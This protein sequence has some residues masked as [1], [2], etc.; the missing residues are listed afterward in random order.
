MAQF[1]KQTTIAFCLLIL[2][3]VCQFTVVAAPRN[4]AKAPIP[5]W[6]K[7]LPLRLYTN[8]SPEDVNDGYHYVQRSMQW[9]VARQEA[10]FHNTYK[11]TSEEGVQNSS[12]IQLSFDPNH[13]KLYLHKVVVWRNGK[14]KDQL[15]LNKVKVIQREQGLEQ[16]IFDES[17]TALFVLEDVRAGDF[18]EYAWSIK[19]RNP[20]FNGKFFNSFHLQFYDPMDELLVQIIMP[21]QRK[22]NYLLHKTDR[23]PTIVTAN[24]NTSYTWHH[25]N[26]Q[27]TPVDSD[28]PGWYNPYPTATV[29]E[30]NSWKEVVDWALPMYEI[31]ETPSKALQAV[32]DSIRS[33]ARTKEEWLVSALRFV[34]D[35]V[36][37]LGMEAGIGGYKPRSPS[38]VFAQRFGDCKD[39]SLLLATMLK[40]LGIEAYPALV[41]SN[42]KGQIK[43]WQPSPY[44]FNHCIVQVT[45]RGSRL[46]YDP[47]ISK[48][49]G[50]S[51]SNYLPDYQQALV[52][53]ASSKGL[54]Q[55][56]PPLD[57]NGSVKVQE[58]FLF[59]DVGGAV[60]LKV[61]T[62]Y[63]GWEADAQRSRFAT[64]SLKDIHK[65]YLNFYANNYPDIEM[66]APVDFIDY[67]T[68]NK[69]TTLEEYSINNVWVEQEGSKGQL[70][71][72]FYPQLLRNYISS[73]RTSKRTMPMGL[74]HP[75]KVEHEIQL[76]LPE[77]WPVQTGVKEV[78]DDA[79]TY[80]SKVSYAESG[81][82]LTLHY[83]YTTLQDHVL[84]ENI[85]AFVR[86]QK[87]M[88]DDIGQRLSY[89]TNMTMGEKGFS[90]IILVVALLA[91]G[92]AAYGAYRLY[93]YDP[94][95]APGFIL[96]EPENIGGW[97]LIPLV[98]L[99]FT[100]L[101]GLVSLLRNSYFNQAVW[102]NLVM[103]SSPNFAPELAGV[104]F[105]ELIINI[106]FIM[107]SILLLRL[108][109]K[110]RSSLPELIK[111][112]YIANALI[113]IGDYVALESMKLPFETDETS[114]SPS[115]RAIVL[116]AI[117][118]PYFHF[119]HRV[120]ETFVV[121][122]HPP[123][124]EEPAQP[125]Q[126]KAWEESEVKIPESI[127]L[128][129]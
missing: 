45:L 32:I 3:L 29:S 16:R 52:L 79:F 5:A 94:N 108:F 25:K 112:F 58:T 97:L 17:L 62:E 72:V 1:Y 119:S 49:R 125:A 126:D 55:V 19:G 118:V 42:Y 120:K 35:D 46:W 63:T 98:I 65:A 31:N 124:E 114:F 20:I 13:E 15:D 96:G 71:A 107:F 60:T 74:M 38:K 47:T 37:Y 77:P 67:E 109:L 22:L 85:S 12:E 53:G 83:T 64:T 48:Q 8:I 73:P 95:P 40:H 81:N 116:A 121:M 92:A 6:A 24:G 28:V 51:H 117:W 33:T 69:F 59:D 103:P 80:K 61:K 41:N 122:L 89:N 18:V 82:V 78:K 21:E 56:I 88:L 66:T 75:V 26:I 129:V 11:I 113:V 104:M 111:A 70:H 115:I 9:E 100:P 50:T 68:G 23:K 10:Y 86:N 57:N 123:V 106:G 14:A 84:P 128:D 99:F 27:A 34:Q 101:A 127:G 2:A 44:A 110:K 90:W 87:I 105:L 36:R 91:F 7:Q 4:V 93:Y 54:T 102:D 39:K 43:D 76:F 30:Y